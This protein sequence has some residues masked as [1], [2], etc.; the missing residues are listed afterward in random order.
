MCSLKAHAPIV[1]F[2]ALFNVFPPC[3]FLNLTI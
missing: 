2:R 3:F 1:I